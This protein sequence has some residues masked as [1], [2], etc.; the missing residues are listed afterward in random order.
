[1]EEWR[2]WR[3]IADD[4]RNNTAL[5]QWVIDSIPSGLREAASTEGRN[6][7]KRK[8]IKEEKKKKEEA[9]RSGWGK[10]G[11]VSRQKR[12]R[13]VSFARKK[14]PLSFALD[15]KMIV[16]KFVEKTMGVL[17]ELCDE[18]SNGWCC[19]RLMIP[20]LWW[21]Q[22]LDCENNSFESRGSAW[23]KESGFFEVCVSCNPIVDVV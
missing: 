13:L 18:W 22:Q 23:K 11:T 10:N 6:P 4:K 9:T 17:W 5:S 8:R 1:M 20:I 12:V 16:L 2:S 3:S 19:E 14:G 21:R 7:L 15:R